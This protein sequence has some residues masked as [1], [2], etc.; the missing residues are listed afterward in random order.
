[1]GS[2]TPLLVSSIYSFLRTLMG[3]SDFQLELGVFEIQCLMD[4]A[5]R[6]ISVYPDDLHIIILFA[7][8]IQDS[9]HSLLISVS[10]TNT[11]LYRVS[12]YKIV[13]PQILEWVDLGHH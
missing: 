10:F 1:M 3:L 6:P 13:I 9:H 5:I 4:P 7:F 2:S 12:K 11:N 8:C